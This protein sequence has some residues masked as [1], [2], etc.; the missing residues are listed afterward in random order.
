[1]TGAEL[2]PDFQFTTDI[3]Y[4]DLTGELWGVYC[5]NLRENWPRYN[6][7]SLY[8][9]LSSRMVKCFASKKS[10]LKRSMMTWFWISYWDDLFRNRAFLILNSTRTRT[11]SAK[12]TVSMTVFTMTFVFLNAMFCIKWGHVFDTWYNYNIIRTFGFE[13]EY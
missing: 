11:S 13:I 5:E 1:M 2:K 10:T 9:E 7:T 12:F 6:G 4:L 3:P 8:S